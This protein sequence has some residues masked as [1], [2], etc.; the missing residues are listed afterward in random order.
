MLPKIGRELLE[1]IMEGKPVHRVHV[2]V[3][4]S[5]FEYAFD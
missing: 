5:D 4:D 1:R 2:G 3:K